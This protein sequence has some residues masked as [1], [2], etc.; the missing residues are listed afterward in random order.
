M[1][2]LLVLLF[3]L[4][5]A[6]TFAQDVIVK[7]DGSTVVCRVVEVNGTEIVYKKWSDLNGSNYVM[8]RSA[9]SAINYENGKKEELGE[10]QN[11]YTPGNQNGGEQHYNDNALLKIDYESRNQNHLKKVKNIKTIG[12]IS[13]GLICA[14][15]ITSIILGTQVNPKEST[16]FYIGGGMA[17]VAGAAC[18]GSF[19]YMANKTRIKIENNLSS[20]S[21]YQQEFKFSNGTSL[22]AGID[23]LSDHTDAERLFGNNAL[24]LGLRFNF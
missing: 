10:V 9:A 20:Q 21:I 3:F 1:K 24:G 19:L 23:L 7:K 13:G 15:G 11:Q 5:S 16:W 17:I 8:E 4:C 22:S 2:H 12:W 14:G 6:S 18:T